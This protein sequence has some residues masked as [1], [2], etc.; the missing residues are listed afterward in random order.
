MG[1]VFKAKDVCTVCSRNASRN[2]SDL[3]SVFISAQAASTLQTVHVIMQNRKRV[4]LLRFRSYRHLPQVSNLDVWSCSLTFFETLAIHY[5]LLLGKKKNPLSQLSGLSGT[6]TH[7]HSNKSL[8]S[9][10]SQR[11]TPPLLSPLSHWRSIHMDYIDWGCAYKGTSKNRSHGTNATICLCSS[12]PINAV[13]FFL[14]CSLCH[15]SSS[16]CI[17]FPLFSFALS[18]PSVAPLLSL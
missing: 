15:S 4:K 5:V 1:N 7:T 17:A 16:G 9:N 10:C 12:M 14:T 8:K 18:F 3:E 2:L 6:H 13:T 11:W